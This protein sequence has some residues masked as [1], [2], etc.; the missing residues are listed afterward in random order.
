MYTS[1]SQVLAYRSGT[2]GCDRPALSQPL[3]H[4]Q[5]IYIRKALCM[6]C[7]DMLQALGYGG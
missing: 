7:A 3:S 6:L 1:L 4:A 2:A 5:F